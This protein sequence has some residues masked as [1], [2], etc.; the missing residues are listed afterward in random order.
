VINRPT[1]R[2]RNR[3]ERRAA[4][5]ALALAVCIAG[6]GTPVTLNPFTDNPTTPT[7]E[8]IAGRTEAGANTPSRYDSAAEY[9]ASHNGRAL[10]VIEGG[11]VVFAAGQ[12]GHDIDQAQP[13]YNASLS[14]WGPLA[15]AAESDGLLD[16]DERVSDTIEDFADVRWKKDMRIRHL[17]H[18]TSG[19]ESGFRPLIKEKPENHYERALTLAMVAAPGD[20]FQFG[21]SHLAVLGE[22][23]RRKLAPQSLDPLSYLQQRLLDPIGMKIADWERDAAGN[24]NLAAGATLTAMEWAKFG[25]LMRN[26]G[27]W[28]GESV[29][30]ASR[31]EACFRGSKAAPRF[32]MTF[33]LNLP[34]SDSDRDSGVPEAKRS[35]YPGGLEDLVVAAGFGNQRLFAI[36]SLDLVIARLGGRS[37]DWRDQDFLA[38]LVAARKQRP[39][40]VGSPSQAP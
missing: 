14:F 24:L 30:D 12:N 39:T 3:F 33:W 28:N 13:I 6:C 8:P 21:P 36:P 32:G 34:V 15:I 2:N 17:L 31:L 19:L 22:V 25:V 5:L 38:L 7:D 29:L 40:P 11:D 20:R 9:S 16:L 23:L 4:A 37:A 26:R 18:Y 1:H 10:V 35:F 27:S